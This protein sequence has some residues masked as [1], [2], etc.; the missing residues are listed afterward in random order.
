MGAIIGRGGGTIRQ[1]TQETRARVD[2]HRKDN[3]NPN[4]NV[5]GIYGSPEN[6]SQACRRLLEVMQQEARALNRPDEINLKMLASNNH[7][8]RI[9]G[10]GGATIKRI[11]QQTDT[12][13]AVSK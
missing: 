8:G 3:S 10:K 12:R 1:I 7:I 13:I 4:E 2:V 6:C 5:I 9:I 11:M